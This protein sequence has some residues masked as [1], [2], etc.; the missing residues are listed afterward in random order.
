MNALEIL[1]ALGFVGR[2]SRAKNSLEQNEEAEEAT[3]PIRRGLAAR[4]SNAL[5]E[6]RS[7]R[8]LTR[9]GSKEVL[10]ERLMLAADA[11]ED[12]QSHSG[13]SESP[14]EDERR[15]GRERCTRVLE[16]HLHLRLRK[17][18]KRVIMRKLNEDSIMKHLND[19]MERRWEECAAGRKV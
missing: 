17:A 15:L 18:K 3:E 9:R 8:G 1:Q 10:A 4:A 12:F 7:S 5:R 6:L 13:A 2:Q 16:K 14:P 19:A 11:R